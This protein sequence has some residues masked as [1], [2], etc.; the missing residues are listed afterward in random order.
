MYGNE[1][2]KLVN[3]LR[4]LPGIGKKQ[5]DKISFYI[6]NQSNSWVADFTK[7][8]HDLKSTLKKCEICN[9]LT[10]NS[11]KCEICLNS[12]R[13][14]KLL[15]VENVADLN[16]FESLEFF[17]GK[18]YVLEKSVSQILKENGQTTPYEFSKL[19]DYSKNFKEIILAL[20]PTLE[21]EI[22]S[23]YLK[24]ILATEQNQITQLAHGIPL[25]AQVEYIDPLTLKQALNNRKSLK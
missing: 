9:N 20:S 5:A 18:Y 23:A 4:S 7:S 6:I 25:G 11:S 2:E 15:V 12:V 8:I 21:G 22:L 16:K 1:Y 10:T 19:Q 14:D 17:S 3:L 24:K 13:I